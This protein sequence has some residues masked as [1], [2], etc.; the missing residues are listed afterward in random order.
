MKKKT[1]ILSLFSTI[2]VPILCIFI[3]TMDIFM[4]KLFLIYFSYID[5]SF[6]VASN[7]HMI[8]FLHVVSFILFK[9]K[10]LTCTIKLPKYYYLIKLLISPLDLGLFYVIL[11][12]ST[13]ETAQNIKVLLP[14]FFIL[15]PFF[16]IIDFRKPYRNG[17]L[18]CLIFSTSLISSYMGMVYYFEFT[19]VLL[20]LTWV[21]FFSANIFMDMKIYHD[22]ELSNRVDMYGIT[23]IF[24]NSLISV[25][26]SMLMS[27]ALGEYEQF[28]YIQKDQIWGFIFGIFSIGTIRAI[29]LII[30]YYKYEP[31]YNHTY[32]FSTIQ[33]LTFITSRLISKDTIVF[34]I[35]T[36]VAFLFGFICYLILQIQEIRKK[37]NMTSLNGFEKV[38]KGLEIQPN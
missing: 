1:I 7:H 22:I 32:L 25:I 5:V 29:N 13:I 11:K 9:K 12:F 31:E 2:I 20:T 19:Q 18:E 15:F 16:I 17:Y 26:S 10:V 4:N 23:M 3:G 27:I 35:L 14:F 36:Y 37:E 8:C 6:F 33:L 34:P 38:D 24:W 30:L 21:F 28:N